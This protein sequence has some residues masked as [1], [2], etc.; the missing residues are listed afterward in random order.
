M[1]R[2]TRSPGGARLRP[3]VAALALCGLAA[4]ARAQPEPGGF[5]GL[6]AAAPSAFAEVVPGVSLRFPEDHGPHRAFRTEWWYVTA[7][8][9]GPDGAR[10]GAQWTLFRRGVEPGAPEKGWETGEIWMA[11]AAV[12]TRDAHRAAETF[13]RGG[14]GQAGVTLGPFEA[15]IDDWSLSAADPDAADPFDALA[16]R[17]RAEGFGFD[18]SLRAEGPLV[19]HGEAG[20]SRKSER[21]QAS[22]YYSQPFY[23]AEGTLRIDGRDVAVTGRAWL[24]REWSTR[25][26]EAGQ[27]GWDW[28]ALHLGDGAKA[29]L[30]RFRQ[31]AGADA[32][33]GTWIAPDG[34]TAALDPADVTLEPAGWTEVAGRETPTRWRVAVASRGLEVEAEALNPRAWNALSVPYWEGPIAFE[35]SHQGVGYLEMTGY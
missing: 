27:T 8:L 29:M 5:A 21:G 14:I 24:D 11:H 10:Y 31:D 2:S 19:L 26:M 9:E 25:P 28:F 3:I 34:T 16:M 33:A 35:G 4:A 32:F 15:W 13:A 6:G 7:N 1:T 12:T 22:Y 17:A 20:Y 23:R 18:L 30:Y